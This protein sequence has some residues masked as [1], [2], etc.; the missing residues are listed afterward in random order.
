MK[1]WPSS[2]TIESKRP[3][4]DVE[5][6]AR[7]LMN[8]AAMAANLSYHRFTGN[9]TGASFATLRAMINDDRSMSQPLTNALGRKM[10]SH[11]RRAAPG[12]QVHPGA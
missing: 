3:N 10:G 5:P 1:S 2:T 8:R 6:F 9:P 4:K 11:L 12:D 7:F